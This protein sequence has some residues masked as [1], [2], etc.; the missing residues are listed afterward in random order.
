MKNELLGTEEGDIC[1][2][3]E[4]D[5]VIEEKDTEESCSCHIDPPCKKCVDDRAFCPACDWEGDYEI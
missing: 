1:N 5:G 2:R 4:C 3:K